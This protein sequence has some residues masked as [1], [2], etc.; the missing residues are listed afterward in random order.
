MFFVYI[1]ASRRNGTIYTGST[2][3]LA[4]RVEQ[5]KAKRLGGFTARYDVDKLVWFETHPTRDQAFR[6]E[7][8]IKDWKRIWK[9]QLIESRN[10]NWL[11]LADDL[12]RLLMEEEVRALREALPGSRRSPG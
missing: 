3:D 1:M 12:E 8:Q 5:H 2:D 6:R 10:P 4:T 11:D 7:R 9:L